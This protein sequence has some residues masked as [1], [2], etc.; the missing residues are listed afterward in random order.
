MGMT[1]EDI[2]EQKINEALRKADSNDLIAFGFNGQ[3]EFVRKWVL[4]IYEQ[5]PTPEQAIRY[6]RKHIMGIYKAT[7]EVDSGI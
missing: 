4:T 6:N 3:V 1:V 2:N 7:W 5:N